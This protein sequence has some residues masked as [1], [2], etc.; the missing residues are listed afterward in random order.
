MRCSV[1]LHISIYVHIELS[2]LVE[3]VNAYLSFFHKHWGINLLFVSF[4]GTIKIAFNNFDP[5][6]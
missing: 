1:N 6:F 4:Y 3:Q 5:V 2:I